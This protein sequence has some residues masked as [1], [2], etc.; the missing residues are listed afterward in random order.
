MD[1]AVLRQHRFDR[2]PGGLHR[3]LGREQRAVAGHRVA[4]QPLV[5]R[6]LVRLFIEQVQLALVAEEILARRA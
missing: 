4:Q 3:I 2:R 1:P 5:G 6:L